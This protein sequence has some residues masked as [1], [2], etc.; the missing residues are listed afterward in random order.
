ME[1]TYVPAASR[2][3]GKPV[4]AEVVTL[5]TTVVQFQ[6]AQPV[7]V[8]GGTIQTDI[9]FT[10]SVTTYMDA[11]SL[12]DADG[13][14]AVMPA[15]DSPK[16]GA[17]SALV[18]QHV[19]ETGTPLRQATQDALL[20]AQGTLATSALQVVSNGTLG[21]IYQEMTS[22]GHRDAFGR[23][24]IAAPLTLFDSKLLVDVA[25]Q[26]W[27]DLQTGG[28]GTTSVFDK[29]NARVV[30]GVSA[31]TAGTRVRQ[32]LRHFNYQPGKSQ[33]IMMTFTLGAP[34]TG[35]TRRVGY[36]GQ[37][38][39]IYLEQTVSGASFNIKKSGVVSETYAQS[40]WNVD[41]LDGTG[42]SQ[43]TLDLSK[44]QIL[45]IDFEWLGVGSVRMGF[46]IDGR[47]VLAHVAHHANISDSV[48]MSSPNL[49]LRYEL[50][51][52]GSGDAAT[53]STICATVVAEG[54]EERVGLPRCTDRGST[55]LVTLNDADTYP[56]IGLRMSASG[57][58]VSVKPHSA[59]A[60][61][62]TNSPIHYS[63]RINPLFVG[64]APTWSA[65]PNSATEVCNT[66]VNTTKVIANTGTLVGS[67]YAD[68]AVPA[69]TLDFPHYFAL[70]VNL[71][72][73]RDEI[74]ICA[75]RLAGGAE[76][77]YASLRFT[78]Q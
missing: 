16:T 31:A 63:L 33:Q 38:D 25:P 9:S 36:F 51:N 65:I 58:N 69:I 34:A 56:V 44:A 59:S 64:V 60:T 6:G 37:Y 17:T 76:T 27:D 40:L 67:T 53:L 13:N 71:S 68:N 35:I 41:K 4:V 47:Y 55:P 23:A 49:P 52:D 61:C 18:V 42:A 2:A 74:W 50:I 8:M 32:T 43:I 48:Y 19:D 62:L 45:F 66:T 12:K 75:A 54:G 70:G 20:A 15:A 73:V 28:A 7:I 26:F 72:G 57:T 3:D 78:E 11:I 30:L 29:P 22:P 77:I 46:I 10:G 14:L 5:G 24:R 21:L 1:V 39:G